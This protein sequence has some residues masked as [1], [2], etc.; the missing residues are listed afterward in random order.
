VLRYYHDLSEQ[1]A[2]DALA[3]SPAAARSLVLR[4]MTTLREQIGRD[5]V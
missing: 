3:C 5:D 4:G 1:Q 2:A